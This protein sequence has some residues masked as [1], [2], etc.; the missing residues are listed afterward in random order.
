MYAYSIRIVNPII[1]IKNPWVS[2]IIRITTDN[3]CDIK[4]QCTISSPAM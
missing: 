2:E 3:Y 4:T 1:I